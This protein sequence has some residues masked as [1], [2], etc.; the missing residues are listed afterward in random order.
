MEVHKLLR[1]ENKN[2]VWWQNVSILY[3][4]KTREESSQSVVVHVMQK[5]TDTVVSDLISCF[6]VLLS[7]EFAFFLLNRD[8]RV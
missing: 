1:L 8:S 6:Y 5:N 7:R 2:S 3:I 4:E